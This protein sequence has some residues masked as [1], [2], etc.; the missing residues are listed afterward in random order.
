MK[1]IAQLNGVD[2]LRHC[3]KMRY[4]VA[5]ILKETKILEIRKKLPDYSQCKTK[6]E[7]EALTKEQSRKNLDEMLNVMLE[8]KPE[9]TIKFL[10]LMIIPE[11]GDKEITGMELAMIGLSVIS[12]KRVMD[13]LASL[14]YLGQMNTGA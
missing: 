6:E 1:T 14:I 3:N 13:F 10:N 4:A 7:R 2:F 11:N 12:D 5:E 9:Q 8:E